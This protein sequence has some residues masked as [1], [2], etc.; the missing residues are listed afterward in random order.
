MEI[1]IKGKT[2]TVIGHTADGR[3]TDDLKGEELEKFAKAFTKAFIEG[4]DPS[5]RINY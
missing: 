4:A 2:Y 5:L 1:V 3:L